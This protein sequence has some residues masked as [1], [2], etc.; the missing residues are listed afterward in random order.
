MENCAICLDTLDN[1]IINKWSC[2]HI[3]H[4]NCIKQ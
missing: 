4:S 1:N 2:N 3:F